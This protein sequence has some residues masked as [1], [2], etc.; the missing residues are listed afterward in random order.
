MCEPFFGAELLLLCG[1]QCMAAQVEGGLQHRFVSVRRDKCLWQTCCV[2][3][4]SLK[5]YAS[6]ECNDLLLRCVPER[7]GQGSLPGRLAVNRLPPESSKW[8]LDPMR[9]VQCCCMQGLYKRHREDHWGVVSP[10]IDLCWALKSAR[11]A[12]LCL[13]LAR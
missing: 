4:E 6:S 3:S 13:E 12:A 8:V 2:W 11:Q 5:T 9:R 7:L 10:S 1:V